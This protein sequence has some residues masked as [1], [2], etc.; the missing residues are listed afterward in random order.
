MN[1]TIRSRGAPSMRVSV[2]GRRL[3]FS[4]GMKI[5]LVIKN[6]AN[7]R[8]IVPFVRLLAERG[9]DLRI[10]CRDIKSTDS[11]ALLQELVEGSEHIEVVKHPYFREPGWSDVAGSMRRTVDLLR[12]H[13]PV[14]RDAPKL[15]ARATMEAPESGRRLARVA[16]ALPGGATAA[17]RSL[18]AVE[19]SI[20]PP[21]RA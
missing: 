20:E 4:D 6:T 1:Q 7:L 3:P 9:N 15:R 18:S 19:R 14:Y 5:L 12:Y 10:A 16:S 11:N 8:T 21:P 2:P 13:E 17:R